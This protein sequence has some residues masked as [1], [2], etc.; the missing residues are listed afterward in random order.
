MGRRRRPWQTQSDRN[1]GSRQGD[2]QTR[3]REDSQLYQ[4]RY[5]SDVLHRIGTIRY[6]SFC[7]FLNAHPIAAVDSKRV[8]ALLKKMTVSQGK[9]F[10]APASV[11]DIEPF[12]QFHNL[13]REEMLESEFACFNDFFF[14]KLKPT[15]RPI[16]S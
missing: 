2:R 4:S 10:N 13:N 11:K 16:G 6:L 3:R 12:I 5:A 1:Y 14:R 8:K 15:A 7:S 9:K